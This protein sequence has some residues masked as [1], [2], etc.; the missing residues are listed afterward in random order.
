MSV[1]MNICT[2]IKS[3][4]ATVAAPVVLERNH[5]YFTLT[6]GVGDSFQIYDVNTVT[7]DQSVIPHN[8]LVLPDGLV[9]LGNNE[10]GQVVASGL[11][12]DTVV[13]VGFFVSA[14]HDAVM[15]TDGENIVINFVNGV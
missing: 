2:Q 1:Q 3:K 10:D 6:L 4:A 11:T 5:A 7:G 14:L 8:R 15:I 12:A 13:N 9:P